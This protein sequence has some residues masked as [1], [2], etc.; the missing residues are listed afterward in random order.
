MIKE[1]II[2][3][4][5]TLFFACLIIGIFEIIEKFTKKEVVHLPTFEEV[6]KGV[7]G[8]IEERKEMA[9]DYILNHS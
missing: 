1:I 5:V 3:I 4:L 2:T 7:N 9:R 6:I 8:T